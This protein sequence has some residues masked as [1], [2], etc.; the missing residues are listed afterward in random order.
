[1]LLSLVQ[2][3]PADTQNPDSTPDIRPFGNGQYRGGMVSST[4]GWRDKDGV[5]E[6]HTGVDYR[7][8]SGSEALATCSGKVIKVEDVDGY[9]LKVVVQCGDSSLGGILRPNQYSTLV[10]HLSEPISRVGDFVEKGKSILG[11]TG[12]SG[13]SEGSHLHYEIRDNGHPIHPGLLIMPERVK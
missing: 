8:P 3:L 12:N 5:K 4:F 7:L 11:K 13:N 10:A 2:T 1:M 6:Y 9:G